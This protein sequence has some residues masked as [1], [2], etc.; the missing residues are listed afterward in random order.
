MLELS[1]KRTVKMHGDR[2]VSNKM[3]EM[4]NRIF[5]DMIP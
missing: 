3:Q 5:E 1:I 4:G 2:N